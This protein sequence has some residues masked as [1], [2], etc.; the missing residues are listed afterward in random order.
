MLVTTH[1]LCWHFCQYHLPCSAVTTDSLP[2]VNTVTSCVT[3]ALLGYR[4]DWGR[5][6][7][8]YDAVFKTEPTGWW[9]WHYPSVASHYFPPSPFLP[10][11]PPTKPSHPQNQ[12]IPGSSLVYPTSAGL[13]SCLQERQHD[14]WTREYFMS[15]AELATRPP[16]EPD[17]ATVILKGTTNIGRRITQLFT[18]PLNHIR[19]ILKMQPHMDGIGLCLWSHPWIPF[20]RV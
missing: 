15:Q 6:R 10:G 18:L 12:N 17:G 16:E 20:Q 19:S 3:T 4:R 9:Q 8:R 2:G 14:L 1:W 13:C 7:W 11:G 5:R